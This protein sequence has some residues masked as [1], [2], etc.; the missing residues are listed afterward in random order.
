MFL[1]IDFKRA[2]YQKNTLSFCFPLGKLLVDCLNP[3]KFGEKAEHNIRVERESWLLKI[4]SPEMMGEL[5]I[6]Y[7]VQSE[8]REGEEVTADYARPK[9]H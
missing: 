7:T 2:E 6:R 4:V 8:Q 9:I 5:R 1:Y 3:K